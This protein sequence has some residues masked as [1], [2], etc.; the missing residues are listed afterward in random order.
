VYRVR[1]RSIPLLATVLALGCAATEHGPAG[2]GSPSL[3]DAIAAATRAHQP[4]VVEFG[5]T[6]C[7]P[8]HVFAEQVLTDPRVRDALREVTFVQYDIDTSAG[9]DAAR[10]C[11]VDGVPAVVG[12]DH[13]GNAPLRK[14]GIEPTADEFLAFLREA[15]AM[16]APRN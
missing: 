7:K 5:A 3:A 9:A 11:H 8:C 16:L 15:E 10:R 4:L 12:V 1:V 14:A 2:G 6:W 13:V